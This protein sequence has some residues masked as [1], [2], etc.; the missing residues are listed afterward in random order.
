MKRLL[1]TSLLIGIMGCNNLKR[2]T[3]GES[4]PPSPYQRLEPVI[5]DFNPPSIVGYQLNEYVGWM[6]NGEVLMSPNCPIISVHVYNGQTWISYLMS[7]PQIQYDAPT[8]MLKFINFWV[9]S[10]YVV[11]QWVPR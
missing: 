8:G 1:L 6:D 11:Y 2:L 4:Y 7:N 10:Y 3:E 9:N 5:P